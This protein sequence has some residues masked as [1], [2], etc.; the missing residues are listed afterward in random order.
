M[1]FDVKRYMSF[2]RS[3]ARDYD[4]EW[5]EKAAQ[6]ARERKGW[7]VGSYLLRTAALTFAEQYVRKKE[8]DKKNMIIAN[9]TSKKY[10]YMRKRR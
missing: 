8:K 3:I 1:R 5:R 10:V 2:E 4:E 9:G 7:T 6:K